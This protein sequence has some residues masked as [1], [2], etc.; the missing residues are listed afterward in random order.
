MRNSILCSSCSHENA[1]YKYTCTNCKSVLRD[2]VYNIDL[3]E[4]ISLIIENPAKA[5]KHIIFAEHKNYF[6]FIWIFVAAKMLVNIRFISLLSMGDFIATTHIYVSY[7]L[8]LL[9]VAGYIFLF[10]FCSNLI[11]KTAK[12]DTRFRD[13]LALITYSLL[14]SIAGI[15]FIFILELVVF[16]GYLFSVN[17]TPFEIKGI[18]AYFFT[19]A[20]I[21]IIFWSIFLTLF[22][23]KTQ[24]NSWIY[25]SVSTVIFY[26][27][28]ALIIFVSSK[29]LFIL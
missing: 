21:L 4:I 24:T 20:E 12:I 25:S 14:P 28:L 5:F 26:S 15:A 13:S 9:I 1:F 22:A 3:W 23:F 16:G 17:P 7:L 10:S 19:G 29:I 8:V 6:V 2:K 18:A 11:N 27:I